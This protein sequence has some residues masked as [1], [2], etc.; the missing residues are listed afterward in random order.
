MYLL[1]P[2]SGPARRRRIGDLAANAWDK[3]HARASQISQDVSQQMSER[4]GVEPRRSRQVLPPGQIDGRYG[5][6]LGVAIKG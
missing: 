4:V 5:G 6:D 2:H 1:D 3:A